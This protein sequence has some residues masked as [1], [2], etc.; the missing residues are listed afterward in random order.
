MAGDKPTL[1]V[2]AD[3]GTSRRVALVLGAGGARGLAHIGAIQ[4]LLRR[5][6]QIAAIGGSSMG[7]LIG[8]IHAAGRLDA[9]RDWACALERGD[10][11]RLLDFTFGNPGFIKGERVINAIREL[12]GDHRIEDLPIPY[13]A[14]ATDLKRQREVWLTR[15]PLFDA[16]RASIAI[17]MVLTPHIINGRELVDG[18]LL[19]P[20][21]IAGT[22][23]AMVDLVVAV[24]VSAQ[25][26]H[27]PNPPVEASA[28]SGRDSPK[29]KGQSEADTDTDA[30][31]SSLRGRIGS[32]IDGLLEKSEPAPKQK[33]QAGMLELMSRSLDTMQAQIARLQLA[34]DP[35]DV[36]V[37]VPHDVCFFYEFWRARELIEIGE[38]ATDKA[39]DAYEAG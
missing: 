21:P 14:V 17:P 9:Y 19:A 29:A 25:V 1:P 13:M 34:L 20:V 11:F 22:R 18:G 38:K 8:G 16:I 32:F 12:V 7:A 26:A 30:D 10:V 15:G 28:D 33:A 27:R 3:S 23:M 6:Y 4:A 37:K 35:P 36:L 2:K 31:A 24:D 5:G 39:L